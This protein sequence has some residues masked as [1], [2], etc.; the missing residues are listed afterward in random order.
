MKVLSPFRLGLSA[1]F[2][3]LLHMFVGIFLIFI[4]LS[5]TE[6]TSVSVIIQTLAL[7]ITYSGVYIRIWDEGSSDLNRVKYGHT[8]YDPW[9]GLKASLVVAVPFF[10]VWLVLLICKL[11]H[12][13]FIFIYKLINFDFVIFINLIFGSP[14]AKIAAISY[15]DVFI[16][17]IF[18][19]IIPV[20]GLIAYRAGY[21]QFSLMEKIIYKNLPKKESK[22]AKKK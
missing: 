8:T 4:V 16:C 9:K 14:D 2:R 17:L 19:L 20:L 12:V 22:T 13:D 21:K 1:L 10:A 3:Y 15:G 7:L 18:V 5:L 6:L 11:I